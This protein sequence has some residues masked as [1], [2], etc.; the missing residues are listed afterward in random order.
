MS[1]MTATATIYCI[2]QISYTQLTATASYYVA[3][4]SVFA[5][6]ETMPTRTFALS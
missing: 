4:D 1:T 2:V 6:V 3:I 5:T